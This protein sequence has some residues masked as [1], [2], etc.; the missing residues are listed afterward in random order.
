MPHLGAKLT[1]LSKKVKFTTLE[2]AMRDLRWIRSIT[3]LFDLGA[4]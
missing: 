2:Q 3:Q 1:S 4:R